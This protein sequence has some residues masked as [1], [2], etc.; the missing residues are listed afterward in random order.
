LLNDGEES[1]FFNVIFQQQE[2]NTPEFLFVET[3]KEPKITAYSFK[4]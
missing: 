3:D 2:V 4:A 1:I